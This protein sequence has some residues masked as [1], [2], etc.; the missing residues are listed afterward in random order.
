MFKLFSASSHYPN[1]F[2]LRFSYNL[3]EGIRI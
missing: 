1:S 2:Y 3:V